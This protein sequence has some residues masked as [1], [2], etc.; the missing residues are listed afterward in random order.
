M[1]GL[2]CCD[3]MNIR[4]ERGCACDGYHVGKDFCGYFEKDAHKKRVSCDADHTGVLVICA[5]GKYVIK[6]VAD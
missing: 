2:C 1:N 5:G 3:V 4:W 6:G